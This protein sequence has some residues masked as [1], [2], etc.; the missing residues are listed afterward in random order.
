MMSDDV[1]LC[2][3]ISDHIRLYQIM[4]DI[5][6]YYVGLCQIMSSHRLVHVFDMQIYFCSVIEIQILLLVI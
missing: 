1:R 3:I 2:Q 4:S 6:A 5:M